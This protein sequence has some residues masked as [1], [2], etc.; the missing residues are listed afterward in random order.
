MHPPPLP[1]HRSKV[2]LSFLI[3]WFHRC[4]GSLFLCGVS[5]AKTHSAP[6]TPAE[7][8]SQHMAQWL[9]ELLP[10]KCIYDWIHTAVRQCNDLSIDHGRVDG[11]WRQAGVQDIKQLQCLKENGDIVGDP[12]HHKHTHYGEYQLYSSVLFGVPGFGQ[13]KKDFHIAEN[14]DGEAHK[15][16]HCVLTEVSQHLPKTQPV[17]RVL[18]LA[19]VAIYIHL[20][21]GKYRLRD[22]HDDRYNP[23]SDAGYDSITK[24]SGSHGCNSVDNGQVAV[25]TH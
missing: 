15:K 10:H 25:H 22:C 24:C 20:Q 9:P 16:A 23:D 19:L 4:V 6:V 3:I 5:E 7:I 17:V 18:R 11:F 21:G 8:S 13:H 1:P 12:A 2:C 14:H